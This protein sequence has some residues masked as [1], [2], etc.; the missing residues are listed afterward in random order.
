VI[1]SSWAD[2]VLFPLQALGPAKEFFCLLVN[3]LREVIVA[4]GLHVVV[5]LMTVR[6]KRELTST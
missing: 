6:E 4:I 3:K 1:T 2:Y 5:E